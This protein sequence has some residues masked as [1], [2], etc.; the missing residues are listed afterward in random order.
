MGKNH[1]FGGGAVHGHPTPSCVSHHH[2]SHDWLPSARLSARTQVISMAHAVALSTSSLNAR[3]TPSAP[4][5]RG[6]V[7][8][9]KLAPTAAR[10]SARAALTTSSRPL[11]RHCVSAARGGAARATTLVRAMVDADKA[12]T[13]TGQ[14]VMII[15][16]DG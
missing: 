15:G 1:L 16:G 8:M 3:V 5:T 4:R 12:K 7:A 13:S 6:S 14:R 10:L 11:A 2:H 9:A